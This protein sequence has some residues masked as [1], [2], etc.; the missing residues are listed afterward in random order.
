M[1]SCAQG[2]A[3]LQELSEL[4]YHHLV[5]NQDTQVLYCGCW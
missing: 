5:K 2:I 1:K 4:Y 3:N